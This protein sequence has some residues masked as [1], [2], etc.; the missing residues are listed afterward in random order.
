MRLRH[1]RSGPRRPVRGRDRLDEPDVR[2]QVASRAGGRQREPRHDGARAAV[3]ARRRGPGRP[4]RSATHR[5][6]PDGRTDA[7]VGERGR[8]PPVGSYRYARPP[9]IPAPKLAPTGPRTT[10]TPPVMYSQPCGPMPSTTA[11]A[12]L[13]RTAKRI[14]ARPTR[15]SR[16]AGRAVQDGVAGDRLAGGVGREVRLRDDRDRAAGQ[17]LADVVVGLA[18]E[19]QRRRR[20][21]ANA[22]NDWPAAPR[23][24]SW[25]GP[26]SSPRSRAPVSAAPNE[27]SAVVSRRPRGGHRALATERG[28][29]A[30]L[31]H[32]RRGVAHLAAGA[33]GVGPTSRPTP[34]RTR[35]R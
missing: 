33:R 18:D 27:R 10:T 23:S 28:G 19:P 22:P 1:A 29:D 12:P 25:T 14:P 35:R 8:V 34:P 24:S 11:S 30:G 6:E 7:A 3:A 9:V 5:G 4:S 2:R 17:A 15:C 26:R 21:P 32:G 31:Q 16:P 13:L 20:A